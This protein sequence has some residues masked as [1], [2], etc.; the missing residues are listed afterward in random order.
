M[1]ETL[2]TTTQAAEFL[3][4]SSSRI[5]QLILEDRLPA[6]KMGRDQLIKKGDLEK[7]SVLPRQRTG[8]PHSQK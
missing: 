1:S 3:G 6:I 2:L 4:V 8:R 7:F 5:R